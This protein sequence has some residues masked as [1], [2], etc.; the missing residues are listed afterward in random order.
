V[1]LYRDVVDFYDVHVYD[2][3]PTLRDLKSV[4]RKPYLLGEVGADTKG[5]HYRDQRLNSTSVRMLLEQAGAAGASAV[6]AQGSE[7]VL[8]SRDRRSLTPTGHV[9]ACFGERAGDASA[10]CETQPRD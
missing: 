7:D 4:L 3:H 5:E 10:G 8:F 2:D 1:G 9:L 6:L